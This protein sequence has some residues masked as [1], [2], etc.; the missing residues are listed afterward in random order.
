MTTGGG[1]ASAGCW[2]WHSPLAEKIFA[3]AESHATKRSY[4]KFNPA[5]KTGSATR[6]RRI[7]LIACLSIAVAVLDTLLCAIGGGAHRF[8]HAGLDSG[9]DA[10]ATLAFKRLIV[11]DGLGWACTRGKVV[12]GHA[13]ATAWLVNA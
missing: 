1:V 6:V 11:E 9:L 12:A 8:C 2:C 10:D 3:H 7:G 13:H 4:S 5:H